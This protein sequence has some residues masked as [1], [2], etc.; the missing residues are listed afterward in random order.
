MKLFSELVRKWVEKRFG[1]KGLV[2]LAVL[3]VIFTAYSKWET[4]L[5]WP[6]VQSAVDHVH[7][8]PTADPNR[9]S[10]LVGRP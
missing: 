8:V 4:I 1:F 7:P 5:K 3:G 9:I 2:V 6:G 10:I